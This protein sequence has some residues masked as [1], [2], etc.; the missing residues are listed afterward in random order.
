MLI[1]IQFKQLNAFLKRRHEV[2]IFAAMEM[3][4]VIFDMDGLLIDSEPLWKEAADELFL[5][6]GIELSLEQYAKTT[7]L[8]TREFLDFWFNRF[9][10]PATEIDQAEKIIVN[11]VIDLVMLKGKPMP[12]VQHIFNF[13]TERGFK[14][15]LATSSSPDLIQVVTDLLGIRSVLNAVSSAKDLSYGKPH[16]EVYMDCARK[17]NTL[18]AHCICFEDSY[19]GMIAA[20]AA[21][22][23]CVIVPSKPESQKLHWEAADLKISTLSNFNELLLRSLIVI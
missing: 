22:M 18:P 13:F 1:N 21:G 10:I 6:F 7:G 16:P 15:G 4:A 8:R 5:N 17:L 2:D 14:I 9:N 3:N 19:N 11:R 12:G 20:K 23:K